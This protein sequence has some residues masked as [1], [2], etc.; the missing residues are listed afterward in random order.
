MA[1]GCSH[2]GE[3]EEILKNTEQA[4]DLTLEERQKVGEEATALTNFKEKGV[5]QT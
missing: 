5:R 2:A 3:W 4:E 1:G